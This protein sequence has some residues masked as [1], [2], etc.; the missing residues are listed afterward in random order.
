MA[1]PL[2]F[3]GFSGLAS[4]AGFIMKHPFVSKMMIFTVFTALLTLAFSHLKGLVSPYI[5]GNSLMSLAAYF[6][7]LDG[8]SIY[9]T[10]LVAGFGVKQVLAFVRS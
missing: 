4:L 7:V 5:V 2:L 1:L 8:I 10:I 3:A 9:L 6:G